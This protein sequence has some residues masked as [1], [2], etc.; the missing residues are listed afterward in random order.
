[1]AS[2][3]SILSTCL[4]GPIVAIYPILKFIAITIKKDFQSIKKLLY[5]SVLEIHIT[6]TNIPDKQIYPS[7]L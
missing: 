7:Q 2:V 3:I 1:M 4:L 5:M 6:E